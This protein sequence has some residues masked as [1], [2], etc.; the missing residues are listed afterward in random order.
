MN[1]ILVTGGAGY[2]GSILIPEL[3]RKN[4]VILYDNF[5]YGFDSI[6]H[7]AEHKNLQIIKNDIRNQSEIKKVIYIN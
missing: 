4:K 6:L 3:L 1:T 7:F 5:M 2:L